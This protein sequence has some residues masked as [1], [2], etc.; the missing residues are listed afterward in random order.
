MVVV[1]GEQERWLPG[2]VPFL[3]RVD[4]E[5]REIELDWPADF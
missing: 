2:T 4:L 5:R 3:K 1:S